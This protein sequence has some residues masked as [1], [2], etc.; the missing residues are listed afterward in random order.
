MKN[1]EKKK[2]WTK[3]KKWKKKNRKLKKRVRFLE[4]KLRLLEEESLIVKERGEESSCQICFDN[5]IDVLF[6]PCCH[7]RCCKHC[8][9]SYLHSLNGQ[10]VPKCMWCMMRIR[11]TIELIY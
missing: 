5:P 8:L 7:T 4:K 3:W 9:N 6:A 2:K 10:G 11:G 1:A